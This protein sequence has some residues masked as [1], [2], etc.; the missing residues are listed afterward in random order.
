MTH[1]EDTEMSVTEKKLAVQISDVLSF[2]SYSLV[3]TY[4]SSSL[5]PICKNTSM[6]II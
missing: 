1:N 4:Y 5:A 2:L 6:S 3:S